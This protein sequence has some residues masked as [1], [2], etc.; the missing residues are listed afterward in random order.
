MKR[1]GQG[2]K[3]CVVMKFDDYTNTWKEWSIP[4]TINQACK[5][6]LAKNSKYYRIDTI[7]K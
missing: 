6:I 5:I 1:K 3:E 7:Q 2:K 4:V